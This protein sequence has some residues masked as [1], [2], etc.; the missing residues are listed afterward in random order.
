MTVPRQGAFI[1]LPQDDHF[2]TNKWLW[3]Q[4]IDLAKGERR[5]LRYQDKEIEGPH[6]GRGWRHWPAPK[7]IAWAVKQYNNLG[8]GWKSKEG[9]VLLGG[10]EVPERMVVGQNTYVNE[11]GFTE[12]QLRKYVARLE[13]LLHGLQGGHKKAGG[14][15][16]VLAYQ[17]TG[18][19]SGRLYVHAV[20]SLFRSDFKLGF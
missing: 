20:P 19:R 18:Y 9:H 4:C 17:G 5:T 8:G 3:E 7:G 12:P 2:P 16:I 13:T 11:A 14:V 1:P 6:H 10:L 15:E